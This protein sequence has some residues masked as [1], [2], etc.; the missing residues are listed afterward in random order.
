MDSKL[1]QYRPPT[2]LTNTRLRKLAA[3]L[4]PA[5][6]RV[7]GTWANSAYFADQ[8]NAPQAPPAGFNGV[9]T[10]QQWRGVVDFSQAV[11]AQIVT[12]FA[13]SQGTRDAAGIWKP[14]QASRLLTYTRSI[15]G[16]IAAAEFMNEPN[17]AAMG[18]A[19]ADYNATVYGKDFEI[20]LL[21]HEASGS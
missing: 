8:D 16:S 21:A 13:V 19:P 20:I 14:D 18:G 3:A 7:S 1:Y 5:Y 4:A 6:M 11:D 12:S 9:L 17:L 10:R 15:G 2:D